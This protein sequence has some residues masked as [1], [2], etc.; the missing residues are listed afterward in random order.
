VEHVGTFY[1]HLVYFVAIWYI[2]PVLVY[3]T[4][5]I[6]ATL[7][8]HTPGHEVPLISLHVSWVE[9]L[10]KTDLWFLIT[11][12]VFEVVDILFTFSFSVTGLGKIETFYKKVSKIHDIH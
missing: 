3:C 1:G 8:Q 2:F 6:L 10:W 5:K 4:K 7:V 12:L 9:N 11:D